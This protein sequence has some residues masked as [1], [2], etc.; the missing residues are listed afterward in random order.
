MRNITRLKS[1]PGGALLIGMLFGIAPLAA[2]QASDDVVP[3]Q[4]AH[5]RITQP[6]TLAAHAMPAPLLNKQVEVFIRLN[7]PAVAAYVNQSVAAGHGKPSKADQRAHAQ[8]IKAEQADV[9]G[10]LQSMGAHKDGALQVGA[11]GVLARVKLKDVAQLAQLPN[12]IA[13]TRVAPQK[14]TLTNSVPWI[15]APQVWSQYGDGDGVRIAIIDTGIDY[16]H[17]DFGGSGNPADY[18]NNDPNVIE[19]GTFPTAKVVGGYD[20]AGHDYDAGDPAH[21]VPHPD[22]DPLDGTLNG[23]GGH[24]TH[25]AGIAAGMGVPGKVGPGVAKG[26]LIY[27]YKVF[28]DTGGSTN[29]TSEGIEAALDPNGD[30]STDDHVDVINMS[31]GSDFSGPDDPSAIESENAAKLGIIVAAAAGNAGNI[32][33]ITGSPSN[34][35]DAISV[36][37]SVSG[38]SVLA[39]QVNAPASV[40]GK[41]EAVEAAIT[42]TLATTGARSGGLVPSVP[43]D[44]CAPLTNGAAIAGNLALIERGTCNF[45]DKILNA[46]NAGATGVVVYNN[47]PGAPIIMGGESTGIT[48]PAEMITLNAGTTL[49]N[50]AATDMLAGTIGPDI[51]TGTAFGDTLADFTSRGPGQGGSQFKPDVTAPGVNIVSANSGSGDGSA[52]LSGTSMA[53]PHIAGVA[54]LLR[55]IFPDLTPI[56][57]KAII[58]NTAVT[59]NSGG[60]GTD[61]PYPLTLQGTGVVRVNRAAKVTSFAEPGGV[62]FGRVNTA[63]PALVHR[64][65][66]LRNLSDKARTFTITQVPNRQL[67]GITVSLQ[68]SSSVQ[69][70]AHGHQKVNLTLRMNPALAPADD[71]SFSQTE[72]DGWFMLTDGTDNLRVGYMAVVDPASFMTM[73]PNG[74]GTIKVSNNG[75]SMGVAEGFTLAGTDGLLADNGPVSIKALGYR[76]GDGLVEFGIATDQPWETFSNR[77]VTILLDA[78]KDGIDDFELDIADG[79][80]FGQPT[81]TGLIIT[82]EFDLRPGH[83]GAL[84]D[85]IV[86]AGD[87]NDGVIVAPFDTVA[88]GGFIP[89][90]FNYTM[91]TSD[92]GDDTDIQ[93]GSIDFANEVVPEHASFSLT[94]GGQ[95]TLSTSGADG[96]MLWLFQ[97]NEVSK[98]VQTVSVK[99]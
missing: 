80:L 63:G 64:S 38:G 25:V 55:P 6:Q 69:V 47:A 26:A 32:P 66:E 41:Y 92:F 22:P 50:A 56:D 84:L 53:T 42:P 20:F 36:A 97:N 74:D 29:L 94:P 4:T 15:G 33:Y 82:A 1:R 46:Q 98:Q 58:Q 88:N 61:T 60:Q 28:G 54:A 30:G 8:K 24:G 43:V 68:G 87:Y 65:F 10:V 35:P 13:V 89:S 83:S 18:A 48:I 52:S 95:G 90:S 2:A 70:P 51:S 85:Y 86:G 73:H 44:G 3:R 71:A 14:P 62:S 76:T 99:H 67:A 57:I 96:R 40:A 93:Q 17:A 16:T 45:S 9:I 31:L 91:I 39:L 12:V 72:V 34:A 59:A 19:P 78:D 77:I 5:E 79:S 49:A 7:T 21:S 27:S 11:N 81:L 37:A 23:G 75:P